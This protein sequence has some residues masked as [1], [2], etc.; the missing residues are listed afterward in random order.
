MQLTRTNRS[1]IRRLFRELNRNKVDFLAQRIE[2]KQ[3]L[4]EF[5]EGGM[6]ATVYGGIDCDG[7]RW[8]NRVSLVPSIITVVEQWA[9]RYQARAEGPPGTASSSIVGHSWT[10]IEIGD[11]LPD[12]VPTIVERRRIWVFFRYPFQALLAPRQ[13]TRQSGTAFLAG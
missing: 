4:A 6:V 10:A 5:Q 9:E 12:H 13:T 1:L 7:G 11:E 8:D 2:R 3:Q